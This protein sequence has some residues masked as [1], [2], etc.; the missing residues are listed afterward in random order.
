MFENLLKEFWLW[1]GVPEEDWWKTDLLDHGIMSEL[2]PRE[3][4]IYIE[5][6]RLINK[7]LSPKEMD[8]FLLGL[9][10]D[11]EYEDILDL[12]AW[13]GS[14][15]F[16]FALVKA[17]I[18]FP[19]AGLRWQLTELLRRD[20]PQRDHFLAALA[21]DPHPYVR[22]RAGNVMNDLQEQQAC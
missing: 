19:Q 17:G 8:M 16:I 14:D 22:K 20:I 11:A 6:E 7:Q 15:E 4:D 9:A 21:N 3:Y 18:S 13:N 1:T 10:I 5:C 12:C 2:F